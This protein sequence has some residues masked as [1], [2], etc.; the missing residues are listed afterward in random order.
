MAEPMRYRRPI[1]S[2][3]GPGAWTNRSR[4]LL[5]DRDSTVSPGPYRLD[6]DWIGTVEMALCGEPSI[7]RSL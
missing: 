6:Q 1:H 5:L 2:P 4:S 3:S 7:I